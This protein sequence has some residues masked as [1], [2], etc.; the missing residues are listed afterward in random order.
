MK[1]KFTITHWMVAGSAVSL[2][3]LDLWVENGSGAVYSRYYLDRILEYDFPLIVTFLLVI[4]CILIARL[5]G[6]VYKAILADKARTFM[7]LYDDLNELQWRSSMEKALAKFTLNEP[8]VL[9]SQLYK[10]NVK[11]YYKRV[12]V[13]A[14]H[15]TAHVSEGFELNALVQIIYEIEKDLYLRF[16]RAKREMDRNVP[17][18]LLSLIGEI[19]HEIKEQGE[20]DEVNDRLAVRYAF[21]VMGVNLLE[22]KLNIDVSFPLDEALERKVNEQK[23]TGILRGILLDEEIYTFEHKGTSRKRG[24]LYLTRTTKIKGTPYIFLLTLNPDLLSEE[25]EFGELERIQQK[26][27]KHIQRAFGMSYNRS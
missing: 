5:R 3:I 23:R 8:H 16:V 13:Q 25:D 12:K 9:A 4:F 21:L 20:R 14:N 19:Y 2:F 7:E 18:P 6:E 24:R 15:I 22:N 27:A 1:I 26:F 10:Y 17:E 11:H